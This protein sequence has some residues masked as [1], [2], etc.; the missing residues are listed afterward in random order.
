M[1]VYS[2]MDIGAGHVGMHK[3]LGNMSMK[4]LG[5]KYQYYQSVVLDAARKKVNDVLANSV[6]AAKD[7]YTAN[8][9]MYDMKVIF[10]GSWQKRGHTSNL[11]LGAVKEAETGLVLDY[12]TV[13]KMCEMC[14]RKTN[15]LQKKQISKEDFEKWLV[16]HK[17]KTL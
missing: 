9:G 2:N 5:K 11:A 14:T 8:N 1:M 10:D 7:F 4:P 16:D 15:L 13:S 6:R 12:E 3:M 17:R